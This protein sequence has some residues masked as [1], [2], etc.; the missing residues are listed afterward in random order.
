[1]KRSIQYFSVRTSRNISHIEDGESARLNS[2]IVDGWTM[3]SKLMIAANR[4]AEVR[5]T[6]DQNLLDLSD[7]V[8]LSQVERLG[9]AEGQID[10]PIPVDSHRLSNGRQQIPS[11]KI[12]SFEL[13]SPHVLTEQREMRVG[14]GN[15]T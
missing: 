4:A 10:G 13:R 6:V 1:M 14:A 15:H 12:C 2:R 8:R 3:V 5:R 11:A 9:G 7:A